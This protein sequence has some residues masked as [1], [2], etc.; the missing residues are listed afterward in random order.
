MRV[1]DRIAAVN[2]V[3]VADTDEY[4]ALSAEHL[5][6]IVSLDELG[7]RDEEAVLHM[8][9]KWIKHDY[10]SRKKHAKDLLN[11]VRF[12]LIDWEK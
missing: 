3:D 2:I 10:D 4:L 12:S 11:L 6:R 7:V 8:I 9:S 1:C 5:R